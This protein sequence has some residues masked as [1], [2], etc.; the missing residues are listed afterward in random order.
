MS[1]LISNVIRRVVGGD[2]GE[3]RAVVRALYLT[4]DPGS[5]TVPPV[6]LARH[7]AYLA[8][9]MHP[10][11]FDDRAQRRRDWE[12]TD[13]YGLGVFG[14][15][16]FCG[17]LPRILPQELE[18]VPA[19]EGLARIDA[20]AALNR[21]MREYLHDRA[22]VPRGLKAV[23][24]RMIDPKPDARGTSF[25]LA[26]QIEQGWDAVHF[27]WEAPA[28]APYLVAFMPEECVDTIYNERKWI[29]RSPLD[30]AGQQQLK[31]FFE[32][33]LRAASLVHSLTGAL[34]TPPAP[35]RSCGKPN[36]C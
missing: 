29:S 6:D 24:R 3:V 26:T 12:A 27:D 22:A 28:E 19:A 34:D 15:E 10:Y 18:A 9:E 25:D 8:P 14:W 35:R 31:E 4:P 16:L 2:S 20:L 30:G 21:A 11:L 5:G 7:L 36:G 23:L 32:K 33:E 1:A 13:I 17:G